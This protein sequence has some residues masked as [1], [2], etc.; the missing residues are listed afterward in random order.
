MKMDLR[1][2]GCEGVDWIQLFE[3]VVQEWGSHDHI[4]EPLG[5]MTAGRLLGCQEDSVPWS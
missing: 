3:V 2:A 1:E 5:F 4:N